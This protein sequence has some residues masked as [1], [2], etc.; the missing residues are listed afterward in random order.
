M[1]S[2]TSVLIGGFL[3]QL[4]AR[5]NMFPYRF[6][7][8]VFSSVAFLTGERSSLLP[9]VSR[10]AY[11]EIILK[12]F[13]TFLFCV[14]SGTGIHIRVLQNPVPKILFEVNMKPDPEVFQP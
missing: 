9:C 4:Y 13:L 8:L 11:S 6:P 14:N 10:P 12:T 2:N 7:V 5:I 1:F 3:A